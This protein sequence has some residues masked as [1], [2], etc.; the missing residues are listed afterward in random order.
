MLKTY[1]TLT[2]PGIIMGNLIPAIAG[3]FLASQ[4]HFN[5]GLFVAAMLGLALVIASACV[6]NNL[7]DK[8]IDE[9][10]ARTKKRALVIGKV[11]SKSAV[12]YGSVLL[13][14][15]VLVLGFYTNLLT[16]LTALTGF[17]LYVV[18]YGI[19][20]RKTDWG[21]V[22][23]SISGA[24]PPVV[25]YV[26]VSNQID[27]AAILLFLILVFWQMPHF[28]A[29]AIYR[30][31]DYENAGIP[32]LPIKKGIFV[33]KIHM[34]FYV[35]A[36]LIA[37]LSLS[38]LGYTGK[39]YLVVISIISLAWLVYSLMGF[40]LENERKWARKMFMLSLV[41]LLITSFAILIESR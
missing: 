3:F 14:L 20:K 12:I 41:V 24:I 19:A 6:F 26:A 16:T 37:A 10:M 28:Y 39:I 21:T 17:F 9:K 11:S 22:I 27:T 32:V 15:G 29:I 8:D 31:K 2:K 35:V 34:L 1:F 36:F 13:L 5:L 25:G 33:T 23:G 18:V 30:L 4:G 7:I 38:I 40:K